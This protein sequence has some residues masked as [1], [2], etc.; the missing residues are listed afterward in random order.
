MSI[1]SVEIFKT[2]VEDSSTGNMI[3]NALTKYFPSY[4]INFDL[5][6]C[7]R[8]LRVESKNGNI[9]INSIIKI[10]KLHSTEIDLITE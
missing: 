2:D 3:V 5:D 1:N 8:I 10:V 9:E 4:I 6:D 7:D